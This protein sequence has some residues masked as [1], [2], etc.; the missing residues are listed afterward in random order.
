MPRVPVDWRSASIENH[1]DFCKKYPN[2]SL[3]F[4]EWKTV[5][6]SFNTAFLTYL[7]ETGERER[8]PLGIGQ[9]SI[10]KKK[11]RKMKTDGFT[12]EDRINLP[13]DWQKSREKGK[14]IYNFNFHSEGYFFGWKWFRKGARFKHSNLWFFKPFRT[15]SRLLASY[16][17]KDEKYQHIYRE[18]NV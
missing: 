6:Y 13:I 4:A 3:S 9:F 1:K 12:G 15:T 7:L 8:L 14:R 10:I 18:W 11:R 17:K 16:I 5:I 2:I